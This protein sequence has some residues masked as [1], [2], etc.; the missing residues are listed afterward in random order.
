MRERLQR[1]MPQK[2]DGSSRGR[3]LHRKQVP[4]GEGFSQRCI[5]APLLQREKDPKGDGSRGSN[6]EGHR[7]LEDLMHL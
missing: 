4:E 5:C 2:G 7:Q 1:E 3:R 6:N